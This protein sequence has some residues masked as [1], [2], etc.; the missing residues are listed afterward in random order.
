MTEM[1]VGDGMCVGGQEA[2][3]PIR[4]DASWAALYAI[5]SVL[6]LAF[7][8]M[9]LL[10]IALLVLAPLPPAQGG[11]AVL[12]YIALHRAVYL[13]EL[14][15]F[16]GLSIPAM[17]VFLAVAM[18]LKDAE[19]N[20]ALLGGLVGVVSEVLALALSSSPQSLSAGLVYLSDQYAVTAVESQ[21]VALASAAEGFLAMANG[22]SVVGVLTALGILLLSIAMRR[23]DYPRGVA[24]LGI[25]AG[26]LGMVSEAFRP[27]LG[28]AYAVYGLLLPVWFAAVGI[29]LLRISRSVAV[30]TVRPVDCE[31]P[32][33]V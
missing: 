11:A 5:G 2:D 12:R 26:A 10:P 18:S 3:T 29:R 14:V 6:A 22:V 24:W 32:R 16:V 4:A 30:R 31:G 1:D 9:V 19:R 17:G 21:R 28:G 20:L 13:T 7:V 8:I 23:G 25:V 15:C 33:A 27:L